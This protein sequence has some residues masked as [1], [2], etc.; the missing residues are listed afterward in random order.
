MTKL[1]NALALLGL[2][3]AVGCALTALGA[4]LGYR[5]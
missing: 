1:T 5:A 3:F 4:G 2:V